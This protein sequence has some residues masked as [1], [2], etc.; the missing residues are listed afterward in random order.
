MSA[1]HPVPDGIWGTVLPSEI[2]GHP[3]VIA[4]ARRGERVIEAILKDGDREFRAKADLLTDQNVPT[5][6]VLTKS[7]VDQWREWRATIDQPD[8][9]AVM[10]GE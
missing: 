2:D 6:G 10:R 5:M 3:V 9:W 7:L 8:V 1:L 4:L